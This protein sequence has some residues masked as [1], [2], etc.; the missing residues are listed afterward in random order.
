MSV[1]R[2]VR[3]RRAYASQWQVKNHAVMTASYQIDRVSNIA[4]NLVCREFGAEI[5]NV[6]K[7]AIHNLGIAIFACADV[8]R[9]RQV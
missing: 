7:T 5:G 9:L 3:L 8:Y 6:G 2:Q 1:A 4:G